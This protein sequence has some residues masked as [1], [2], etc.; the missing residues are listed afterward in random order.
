M[1]RSKLSVIL[2]ARRALKAGAQAIRARQR[3]RLAEMVA[4]ARAQSPYYPELYRN[5]ANGADDSTLLPVT[6]KK[7]LMANFDDWCTDREV[8]L[9]KARAFAS[10]LNRIGERFLGK[11]T[12]A[13]T[14]GTTGTPGIFIMDEHNMA[15]TNAMML[16]MLGS[17]LGVGDV[18]KILFRGA[19]IAMNVAPGG[20]SATGVAAARLNKSARGRAKLRAFSSHTPTAELV[21]ELNKYRP[22]LIAPYASVAKLLALEQEAGRLNISPVQIVC[23]AEGLP[24]EDYGRI[25]TAFRSRVRNSYACTECSFLS[26]SCEHG[27]LHV[28]SDWLVLEPV[29]AEHRPVRPGEPS[30][31]VLLSNLANQVQP[32]LRYDLGDSVT[33]RPDPCPCGNPLPAIRV[34][35]RAAEVMTFSTRDGG[36][37]DIPPLALEVDHI[38]GVERFQIVQRAPDVLRVRLHFAANA[39]TD[40]IWQI[41]H[42]EMSHL[43]KSR[44]LDQV[45]IEKA[46]EGPQQSA[47]GKFR[48][49]IPLSAAESSG[50]VPKPSTKRL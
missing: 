48:T 12:L 1:S 19:R 21:D 27:W 42:S 28:N 13:T 10:D 3:R 33:F 18:L 34:R 8:T 41:V 14:S 24:L 17:W 43:L 4:F 7:R 35:G 36:R 20:H 16:R 40:R 5:V 47:G 30:H 9:E 46:D 50:S 23:A 2:D 32:I 22:A 6:D 45:M 38:D 31:T 25:A 11:Y 29:D 44:G 26:Y 15:V 37:V 49:V 39:D